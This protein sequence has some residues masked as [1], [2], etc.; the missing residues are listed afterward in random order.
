MNIGHIE[1]M[2]A[3]LRR[4]KKAALLQSQPGDGAGN[5]GTG[6]ARKIKVVD[7]DYSWFITATLFTCVAA[8][9]MAYFI[10]DDAV[11][12][13][14]GGWRTGARIKAAVSLVVSYL[15]WIAIATLLPSLNGRTVVNDGFMSALCDIGSTFGTMVLL[16][17]FCTTLSY[18]YTAYAEAYDVG[19]PDE[20]FNMDDVVDMRK[21][22][23]NAPLRKPCTL[24]TFEGNEEELRDYGTLRTVPLGIGELPDENIAGKLS[25]YVDTMFARNKEALDYDKSNAFE[26]ILWG[27]TGMVGD[28]FKFVLSQFTFLDAIAKILPLMLSLYFTAAN[29]TAEATARSLLF[30]TE[31]GSGVH[32][33]WM[34]KAAGYFVIFSFIASAY[35][36]SDTLSQFTNPSNSACFPSIIAKI[37]SGALFVVPDNIFKGAIKSASPPPNVYANY[38]YYDDALSLL[39]SNGFC[40][41]TDWL[42]WCKWVWGTGEVEFAADDD[43]DMDIIIDDMENSSHS[44]P[45]TVAR[46]AIMF[47]YNSIKY[48]AIIRM[49]GGEIGQGHNS[50]GTKAWLQ[51]GRYSLI[52]VYLSSFPYQFRKSVLQM[53]FRPSFYR[54]TTNFNPSRVDGKTPTIPQ[55]VLHDVNEGKKIQKKFMMYRREYVR[56]MLKKTENMFSFSNIKEHFVSFKKL[57]VD[58]ELLR[59]LVISSSAG[60]KN[61]ESFDVAAVLHMDDIVLEPF[62]NL[63]AEERATVK[64]LKNGQYRMRSI[65]PFLS[66]DGS[67]NYNGLGITPGEGY[68]ASVFPGPPALTED[69]QYRFNGQNGLFT[70]MPI[71]DGANKHGSKTSW[72]YVIGGGFLNG[73]A[74]FKDQ[75]F[76][77]NTG[78]LDMITE[79]DMG[80][81]DRD[82]F[83]NW[84][85]R[86]GGGTNTTPTDDPPGCLHENMDICD[87]STGNYRVGQTCYC[88]DGTVKF[89]FTSDPR[90]SQEIRDEELLNSKGGVFNWFSAED[91]GYIGRAFLGAVGGG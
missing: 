87:N 27:A 13:Q 51:E 7:V 14:R 49:I 2:Q 11:L 56:K 38:E 5:V 75:Y 1:E 15:P 36:G 48:D 34:F 44:W 89:Q 28:T 85:Q 90:T 53:V 6:R 17:F 26:K 76:N 78:Q 30:T 50:Q 84:Y 57:G 86:N 81:I 22:R 46:N 54:S 91:L 77:P 70:L 29:A 67:R 80:R 16:N 62:K 31:K 35:T 45:S 37:V 32:S 63:S 9:I 58:S 20:S 39:Q 71:W 72:N 24:A 41:P 68:C 82:T 18:I 43:E 61:L 88:K 10:L 66:P 25:W 64:S 59:D 74:T 12:Y 73:D 8:Y 4:S 65:T 79:Y 42:S 60:E 40:T 23:I 3:L 33:A 19:I 47:A 52:S 83:M 69:R 21:R 55:D